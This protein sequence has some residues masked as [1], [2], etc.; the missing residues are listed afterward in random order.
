MDGLY[1]SPPYQTRYACR[2]ETLTPSTRW[3][4]VCMGDLR[5]SLSHPCLWFPL[6]I[7]T[8]SIPMFWLF[9]PFPTSFCFFG[10]FQGKRGCLTRDLSP[11]FLALELEE[12]LLE[13]ERGL[14]GLGWDW[15]RLLCLLLW[16]PS[17]C[18]LWSLCWH[19]A[20][21]CSDGRGEHLGWRNTTLPHPPNQART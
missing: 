9:T 11:T 20:A 5:F 2:L 10:G 4:G 3:G 6:T 15:G 18:H 7:T 17:S 12:I 21:C 8:I 19:A 14:D 1:L 13:E 16:L